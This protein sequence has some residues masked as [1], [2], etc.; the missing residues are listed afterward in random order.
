MLD[1]K[2]L[3]INGRAHLPLPHPLNEI[4]LLSFPVKKEFMF[5]FI[6]KLSAMHMHFKGETIIKEC[7]VLENLFQS[8]CTIFIQELLVKTFS[9]G[10]GQ[11][12]SL[13]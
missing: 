10:P 9:C 13:E 1:K 3:E 6:F 5:K 7:N 2:N 4:W 8:Q 12:C 11:P